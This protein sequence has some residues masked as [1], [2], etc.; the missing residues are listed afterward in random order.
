MGIRKRRQDQYPRNKYLVGW[1]ED[2]SLHCIMTRK[3]IPIPIA[4]IVGKRDLPI[5]VAY[6]SSTSTER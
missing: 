3:V 4:P 1:S 2:Q 5:N 6:T